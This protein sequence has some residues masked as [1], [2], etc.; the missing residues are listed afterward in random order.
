[1]LVSNSGAPQMRLPGVV[2]RFVDEAADVAQ[3]VLT[4]GIDLHGV[5]KPSLPRGAQA[6][7]DCRTLAAI[8]LVTQQRHV[9][10]LG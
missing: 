1:M 10:E 9:R 8:E 3:R 5:S 4:V 7:G 2:A 6:C